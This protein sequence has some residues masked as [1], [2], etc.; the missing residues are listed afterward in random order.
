MSLKHL[1]SQIVLNEVIT[2]Y[3]PMSAESVHFARPLAVDPSAR[4]FSS[5]T[6]NVLRTPHGR[7]EMCH[8]YPV[9]AKA[10]KRNHDFASI[11]SPCRRF[12]VKSC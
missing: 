12:P 6:A 10:A 1:K 4:R 3:F 2:K 9:S 11:M 7:E 5:S 8:M